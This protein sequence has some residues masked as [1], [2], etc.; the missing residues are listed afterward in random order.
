M[1]LTSTVFTL[2]RFGPSPSPN[3]KFYLGYEKL[4]YVGHSMGSTSF[5]VMN[6]LDQSWADRKPFK[7]NLKLF[8]VN[9]ENILSLTLTHSKLLK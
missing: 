1:E 8:R 4:L 5:M 6:S 9:S 7:I 3:F 2:Q